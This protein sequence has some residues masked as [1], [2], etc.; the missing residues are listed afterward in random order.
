M[1]IHIFLFPSAVLNLRTTHNLLLWFC[2]WKRIFL[3]TQYTLNQ[4]LYAEA[5]GIKHRLQI[6]FN[7]GQT[8]SAVEQEVLL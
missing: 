6:L 4:H 1:D 3:Y 2:G 5:P 7:Y 8:M